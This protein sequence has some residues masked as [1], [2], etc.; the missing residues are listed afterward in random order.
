MGVLYL[1]WQSGWPFWKI[2]TGFFIKG[3]P[4]ILTVLDHEAIK[5]A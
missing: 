1:E 4:V 2:M 5:G 3:C